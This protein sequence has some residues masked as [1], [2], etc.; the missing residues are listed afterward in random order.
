M[1]RGALAGFAEAVLAY[2]ATGSGKTASLLGGPAPA[3]PRGLAH[4]VARREPAD[5]ASRLHDL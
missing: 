5:S 2:G 4:Y 3:G 1:V